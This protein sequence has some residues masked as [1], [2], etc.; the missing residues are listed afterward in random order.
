ML[1]SLFVGSRQQAQYRAGTSRGA[2][3]DRVY[4]IES[5]RYGLRFILTRSCRII[6][7]EFRDALG[8]SIQSSSLVDVDKCHG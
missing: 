4:T 5:R 3:R 7:Q 8:V 6:Q 1:V 2:P